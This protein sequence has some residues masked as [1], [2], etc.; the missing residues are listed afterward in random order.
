[1]SINLTITQKGRRKRTLPLEVLTGSSLA[2]GTQGDFR[3]LPGHSD[4]GTVVLYD[5][6]A[7]ARGIYVYWT[8]DEKNEVRLRLNQ[9][10]SPQ[11][12]DALFYLVLRICTH[13]DCSITYRGEELSLDDVRYLTESRKLENEDILNDIFRKCAELNPDGGGP[14]LYGVFNPLMFGAQD[15]RRFDKNHQLLFE[16]MNELQQQGVVCERPRFGIC[17]DSPNALRGI[18]A[19]V[20][21]ERNH[22][23]PHVP[24]SFGH[25]P[26]E[27]PFDMPCDRWDVAMVPENEDTT[28]IIVPYQA[29]ASWVKE[30]NHTRP[31]DSGS[32]VLDPPLTADDMHAIEAFSHDACP[33]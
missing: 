21:G 1:M 11:E 29:F 31:Y 30:H 23:F 22:A 24:N 27:E 9:P 4:D 6:K 7:I 32:F 10:T 19:T 18:F 25:L 17:D 5:P 12:F 13:W 15:A 3:F 33:Q 16:W 28:A 20:E 26:L 2:Y 8:K 14:T